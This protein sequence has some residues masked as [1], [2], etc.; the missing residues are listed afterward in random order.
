M[1]LEFPRIRAVSRSG[2][3]DRDRTAMILAHV[4]NPILF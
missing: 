4:L 2:T 3:L 1:Q